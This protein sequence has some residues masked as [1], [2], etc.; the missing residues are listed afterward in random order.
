MTM[1]DIIRDSLTNALSPHSLEVVDESHL[2]AGHAGARPSGETHFR[3]AIVAAA[4]E[5]QNRLTRQRAVYKAL[6]AQ[7][8]DQIH[9]LALTTQTPAE[10]E[11]TPDS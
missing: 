5:G 4:F 8:A 9:A 7:M 10:A 2:H 6:A 1:V 11:E 3:V